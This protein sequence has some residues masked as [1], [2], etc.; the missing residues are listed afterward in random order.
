MPGPPQTT[1][2][3]GGH[4][5]G[6][7]R[8]PLWVYLRVG[9][10]ILDMHLHFCSVL[11][12]FIVPKRP[13]DSKVEE[14]QPKQYWKGVRQGNKRHYIEKVSKWVRIENIISISNCILPPSKH[15]VASSQREVAFWVQL[16]ADCRYKR[17][18][19]NNTLYPLPLWLKTLYW[20]LF[21][22]Y[23][24]VPRNPVQVRL[25]HVAYDILSFSLQQL[26]R[27]GSATHTID[28]AL[29]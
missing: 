6:W 8:N 4:G 20:P 11:Q 10:R 29:D 9:Y 16:S 26:A 25:E 3:R 14:E 2:A 12:W 24:I 7:G 1:P 19:V 27:L 18:D 22:C 13:L 15:S 21:Y 28:R 17:L 5:V 23:C